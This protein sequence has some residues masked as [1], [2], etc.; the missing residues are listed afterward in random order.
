MSMT[1]QLNNNNVLRYEALC[2][3][4]NIYLTNFWRACRVEMVHIS[5]YILNIDKHGDDVSGLLDLCQSAVTV[6]LAFGNH[7]QM[8]SELF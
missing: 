6:T 2:T 1:N 8:N 3:C 4:A 5:Y 7:L